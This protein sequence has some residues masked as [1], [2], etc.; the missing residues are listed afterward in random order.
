[1]SGTTRSIQQPAATG[2]ILAAVAMAATVVAAAAAIA[3][4]AANLGQA[5]PNAGVAP[6]GVYAP[7][8]RDL[9]SR[10]LTVSHSNSLILDR[11]RDAGSRDTTVD[12]DGALGRDHAGPGTSPSKAVP[13]GS[14]SGA[15][16]FRS[17]RLRAQ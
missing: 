7:A 4:G 11:A 14:N 1:M 2:S 3:W 9:G 5:K 8:V 15:P 16:A 17:A 13:T 10:D 12:A 6:V